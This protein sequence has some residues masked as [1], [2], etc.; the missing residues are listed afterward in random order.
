V[1]LQN[2]LYHYLQICIIEADNSYN[3]LKY[4]YNMKCG[5]ITLQLSIPK[6]EGSN[7]TLSIYWLGLIDNVNS[8]YYYILILPNYI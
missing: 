3:W 2:Q 4:V 8:E 1:I 6:I 7:K 5:S